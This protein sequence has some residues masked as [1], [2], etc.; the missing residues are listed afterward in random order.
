MIGFV[1]NHDMAPFVD[2]S[3]QAQHIEIVNSEIPNTFI[4]VEWTIKTTNTKKEE[5]AKLDRLSKSFRDG[6]EV[7]NMSIS[8]IQEMNLNPGEIKEAIEEKE[9]LKKDIQSLKVNMEIV[10]QTK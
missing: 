10:L 2:K 8:K 1:L 3:S 7:A 6:S 9:Q 5:Q 4:D